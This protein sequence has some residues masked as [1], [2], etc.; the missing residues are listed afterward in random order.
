MTIE[1][2]EAG[3][4]ED[5]GYIR[6]RVRNDALLVEAGNMLAA[7]WHG[8]TLRARADLQ[9]AMASSDFRN[10]AFEVLDRETIERYQALPSV[11]ASF[12]SRQLVKDFKP[13][14]IVE[15]L[16]GL[17]GLDK[18][19]ELTEYPERAVSKKLYEI[20]VSKR[21]AR[22]AF[23]W[24][25]WINDDL[26]ELESLPE[27]LAISARETEDRDAAL[28]LTDG[29]GPNSAFFNATAIGGT[30]SNLMA[31]NPEL[32]LASLT[33]AL[34]T[35]YAR[36]DPQGRPIAFPSLTL[37]VPG[38]LRIQAETILAA[39]IV[40]V[41]EGTGAGS[42]ILEGPNSV[43]SSVKLAVNPWLDVLDAGANKSKTWYLV[44]TPSSGRFALALGFLR[45]HEEP[46]VRVKG[47]QGQAIGGGALPPTDGG[48]EIDDIQYRVRHVLGSSYGDPIGTLVSTGAGS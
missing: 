13:K 7:A 22:F 14:K 11:W 34:S 10:A 40:R 27:A 44:P 20:Q 2:T 5:S 48:F 42:R 38:A 36:T 47:H 32:S 15:L 33:A 9:E 25:S 23:S 30:T 1:L 19:P 18:V 43:A 45:G 26:D 39:A 29:D 3:G 6:P 16:G 17:A 46:Q 41:Q 24:E 21:G 37:V 28:L 12:A 8:T 31:G 35:I 4:A